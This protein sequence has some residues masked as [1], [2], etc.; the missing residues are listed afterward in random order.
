VLFLFPELGSGAIL[1]G[2]IHP[3]LR[4]P[5]C[6]FAE[7]FANERDVKFSRAQALLK[8][9]MKGVVHIQQ[10]TDSDEHTTAIREDQEMLRAMLDL[11]LVAQKARD[12]ELARKMIRECLSEAMRGVPFAMTAEFAPGA[13]ELSFR[14]FIIGVRV[15]AMLAAAAAL[16]EG[17][18]IKVRAC[19][20]LN[21]DNKRGNKKPPSC[22]SDRKDLPKDMRVGY[23]LDPGGKSPPRFFCA[24]HKAIRG[25]K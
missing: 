21:D 19:T 15:A 12:R 6:A 1:S 22:L 23:V 13:E 16:E 3:D 8:R 9:A 2:M 24:H 17:T 18:T 7:A 25:K 14:P 20:H 4:V 5:L 11:I 10:L